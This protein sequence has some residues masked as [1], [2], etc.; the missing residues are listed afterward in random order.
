MRVLLIAMLLTIL[1]AAAMADDQAELVACL[2]HYATANTI[3][4]DGISMGDKARGYLAHNPVFRGKQLM[5]SGAN[6]DGY[7]FSFAAGG[8]THTL[9]CVVPHG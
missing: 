8:Q 7:I 2:N 1:P 5:I 9:A 3:G 4:P 6:E